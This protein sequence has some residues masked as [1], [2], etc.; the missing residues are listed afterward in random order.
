[1]DEMKDKSTSRR[2][3]LRNAAATAAAVA[4]GP[5]AAAG[6]GGAKSV[7]FALGSPRAIGANDRINVAHVGLGT[8]GHGA[9]VRLMK[10]NAGG[11]N[12]QQVAVCDLYGRR[13]R[14]SGTLLGLSESAWYGDYRKMLENK[15]IDA[16]VIA[17]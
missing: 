1:M 6:K 10:Q 8:Q 15:D 7:A 13:L 14:Q 16:V 17:T 11:N 9:H 3:F 12:I 2:A 5:A 4:A